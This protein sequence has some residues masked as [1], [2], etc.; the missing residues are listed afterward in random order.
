ML[1]EAPAPPTRPAMP[2]EATDLPRGD[3]CTAN[4][5]GGDGMGSKPLSPPQ[6]SNE[7]SAER[8]HPDQQHGDEEWPLVRQRESEAGWEFNSLGSS[9]LAGVGG[10]S[11]LSSSLDLGMGL[12]GDDVMDGID[13]WELPPLPPP[14]C[15]D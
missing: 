15:F 9:E 4:G 13:A 12:L 2:A 7:S 1:R 8:L 6:V 10:P 11:Q 14:P 5:A 3:G